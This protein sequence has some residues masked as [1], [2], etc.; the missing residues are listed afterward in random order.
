MPLYADDLSIYGIYQFQLQQALAR[1]HVTLSEF[2]LTV[3]QTN[4]VAI[5][6]RRGGR[7]G[8]NDEISIGGFS[9][10][11]TNEFLYVGLLLLPDGSNSQSYVFERCRKIFIEVS[12][13]RKPQLLSIISVLRLFDS[14]IVPVAAY[15]VNIIWQNLNA[16][17][18]KQP[19]RVKAFYLAW[20]MKLYQTVRYRLPMWNLRKRGSNRINRDV[21]TRFAVHWFHQKL[22]CNTTRSRIKRNLWMS[23]MWPQMHQT[24]LC[25]SLRCHLTGQLELF[26]FSLVANI[27][28]KDLAEWV[29]RKENLYYLIISYKT[30][31]NYH[32]N[33]YTQSVTINEYISELSTLCFIWKTCTEKNIGITVLLSSYVYIFEANASNSLYLLAD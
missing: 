8:A 11:Y 5:K 6:C 10:V 33:I 22:F 13:I 29:P 18:I 30:I 31:L 12:T 23:L 4:V 26:N 3:N 24:P 27:R 32:V 20:V 15:R 25:I 2:G 16:T 17:S 1:L 28:H 14:K 21:V 7:V 19:Y 9:L